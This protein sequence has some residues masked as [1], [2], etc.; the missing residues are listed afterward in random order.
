[1]PKKKLDKY[2][3]ELG[4]KVRHQRR[5]QECTARDLARC[6]CLSS[7]M[8]HSIEAARRDGRKHAPAIAKCLNVNI[9]D[10]L[11]N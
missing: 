7:T 4:R 10:I 9:T 2:D 1:M 8:V 6:L 5:K 3:V 11:P